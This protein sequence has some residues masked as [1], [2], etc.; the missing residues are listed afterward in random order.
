MRCYFRSIFVSIAYILFVIVA[1]QD[2]LCDEWPEKI[3]LVLDTCE[4]LEHSRE[5]RIPLYLWAAMDPGE[6]D[7]NRAEQLVYELDRR[8]VGLICSW[9]PDKREDC[10]ARGLTVA[11]AQKKLDVPVNVNATSIL[12]TFFNGDEE[13]AH[14]NADGEKFFDSSFGESHKMGC[15]FA[16]E[17]RKDEIRE[18]VEYY[19][20]AY[21]EAGIDIKFIWADWEVDGP[22]EFNHAHEA[23]KK[24]VRCREEVGDIDNF[25]DFQK[26]LRDIRSELQRYCYTEPVLTSHP[27]ALVGNYAVYPHDGYR[28][29]YDYFEYFVDGQP[30]IADTR[31]KYR[32]WYNDFPGTGY[33]Y[34]M[35]VVYSWARLFSWYDFENY[36]Y[37]WFYNMLKVASNA[38]KNTPENVPIISFVHR[39]MIDPQ[40]YP[41]PE[42]TPF[43]EEMYQELLWHMLFRGTDAFYMWSGKNDFANEIELL[44]PVYAAAQEFGDFLENGIPVTFDVPKVAG[45]VVSALLFDDRLLVRRTDFGDSKAPVTIVVNSEEITVPYSP[46]NCQIIAL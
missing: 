16:L 45:V 15:P 12:Y 32:L 10:L 44:H 5:A 34:A 27:D 14:I 43:S 18:R 39:N 30:Y 38:G 19:V 3:Q 2:V 31:A 4:P 20:R 46:G 25:L 36:D 29:W 6:M 26:A 22:L 35:P 37:R 21:R 40:K 28:Y 24:C 1:A 41:N 9:T 11:R 17:H 8:G 33:T 7:D 23:S 13:T 42:L